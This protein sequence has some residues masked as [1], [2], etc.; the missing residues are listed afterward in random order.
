MVIDINY[1]L[2][3]ELLNSFVIFIY[4]LHLFVYLA[5]TAIVPYLNQQKTEEQ[6]RNHLAQTRQ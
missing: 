5:A 1:L 6:L 4:S 3:I 2:E